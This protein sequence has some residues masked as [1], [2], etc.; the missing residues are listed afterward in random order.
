VPD[1]DVARETIDYVAITRLQSAYGDAVNRRAW[2]EFDQLFLPTAPVRVDTVTNPVVDVTGPT[3]LGAFIAGAIERFAF[4]EFVILNTHVDLHGDSAR[5]R[6]FM[7]ELRQEHDEAGGHWSNA[8]GVYHDDYVRRDARWWFA[9][10]RYQS[11]ARFSTT[12]RADV[13]PFPDHFASE[14]ER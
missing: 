4:F 11:L 3:E 7:C 10:R 13:F 1:V 2:P 8:F 12:A 14:D 9:R 6:V 5:G